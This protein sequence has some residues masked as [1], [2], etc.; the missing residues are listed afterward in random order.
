MTSIAPNVTSLLSEVLPS[1]AIAD[2]RRGKL[3]NQD[4]PNDYMYFF[5]VPD[6]VSEGT[7]ANYQEQTEIV[8]RTS[9]YQSYSNNNARTIQLQ[10]WLVAESDAK[11]EV[12]DRARWLQS[13]LYPDYQSQVMKP[14]AKLGLFLGKEFIN[15]IGIIK[16]VDVSWKA[17]YDAYGYP[18]LAEIPLNITEVVQTPYD[19]TKFHRT[20]VNRESR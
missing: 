12:F 4:D 13:F 10:I 9:P 16:S 3:V 15:I 2:F 14:P 11:V 1:V 19:R 20:L 7:S 6:E 18:M 5:F 17:P 8:G